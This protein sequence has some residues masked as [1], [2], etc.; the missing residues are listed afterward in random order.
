MFTTSIGRALRVGFVGVVPILLLG[1]IETAPCHGSEIDLQLQPDPAD[2]SYVEARWYPGDVSGVSNYRLVR[3]DLISGVAEEWL[4]PSDVTF[5]ILSFPD[6]D[7]SYEILVEA[8]DVEGSPVASSPQEAFIAGEAFGVTAQATAELLTTDSGF[9]AILESCNSQNFPFLFVSL[10]VEEDG[11][12]RTDL[13]ES[14]FSCY[15]DGRLQEDFFAVVPPEVGGGI[16]QADVVFLIDTSGSM[17]PEIA[18]VKAN[19]QTFAQDLANSDVDFRLG[20]VKFGNSSGP[21]PFVFNSGALTDDIALFQSFV[22]SLIA[23]GGFEPGFL[24]IRLA[25]S[26]FQFRPGSSL[27]FI[28]ISDEDSDDRDKIST[29]ELLLANEVTAHV[30]VDCGF[31]SSNS[32]YCLPCD[33][34]TDPLGN[35]SVRG[36]TDGLLFGVRDPFG[37]ILDTI[38]ARTAGTYIARYRSDNPEFDGTERLVECFVSDNGLSDSV[39]CSYVPGAA[40]RIERTAETIALSETAQVAGSQVRIEAFVTD[41]V[42]PF[43]TEV[44]VFYRTTGTS[45]AYQSRGMVPVDSTLYSVELPTAV[46]VTPGVD[47]YISAA[48]GQVTSFDPSTEP[49]RHPYQI[50]VLPNEPPDIAHSPL[51]NGVEGIA[52]TVSAEIDDTTNHL[53]SQQLHWRRTGTLIYSAADMAAGVGNVFEAQI[54]PVDVTRD[55][56]DYYISATDDLGLTATVGT[57]DVPFQIAVSADSPPVITA[58]PQ[59][60]N[61]SRF[62]RLGELLSSDLVAS[63]PDGNELV[64]LRVENL[65]PT[66]RTLPTLPAEGNPISASL[67]WR[68]KCGEFGSYEVR[69][70]ASEPD[71]QFTVCPVNIGF[72]ADNDSDNDCLTDE[73]ECFWKTD[74]RDPDTDGDALF[75]GWEVATPRDLENECEPLDSDLLPGAHPLRKDIFLEIDWMEN[76]DH[77]HRP[78]GEAISLVEEAFGNAPVRVCETGTRQN[79]PCRDDSECPLSE[80]GRGCTVQSGIN[81]HIDRDDSIEHHGLICFE[82]SRANCPIL[83]TWRWFDTLKEANF[84]P[85]RKRFWH[86][87]IFGHEV[88]S[89]L[90]SRTPLGKAEI[91]GN[92]LVVGLGPFSNLCE[93]G[94][95]NHWCDEDSDCLGGT[96]VPAGNDVGV[97]TAF[98]QAGV[99]MHE[100]GHN[101]GLRHGGWEN[102]NYKPN[103]LSVMNYYFPTRGI[104]QRGRTD[105]RLDYSGERLNLVLDE[106]ELREGDG[107]GDGDLRVYYFCPRVCK[108]GPKRGQTCTALSECLPGIC[109][110]DEENPRPVW[111]D[112]EIDWNCNGQL[113]SEH[114]RADVNKDHREGELEGQDDWVEIRFD[115]QKSPDF[116]DFVHQNLPEDEID[117]ETVNRLAL[118][119]QAVDVEIDIKPGSYPNAVNLDSQGVVPVAILSSSVFDAASIIPKSVF[120]AGSN[121]IRHGGHIEDVNGD[122]RADL[123][124]HYETP[125]LLYLQ[126]D[127]D[128]GTIIGRTWDRLLVLGEDS[129]RVVSE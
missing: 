3:V 66:A 36:A 115:F 75:D 87:A 9:D 46:V 41:E 117:I 30:A 55:G 57:A 89:T 85:A 109:T 21:N 64:S 94:E 105:G 118:D 16:R 102:T 32:D 76:E 121:D 49:A 67:S 15:E 103:Y 39:S 13:P 2:S 100:F 84:E 58:H 54:P 56:V 92:D 29:L 80:W 104:V 106:G 23:S 35:C 97:G 120:F 78:K 47:Y 12:P 77:S 27:V 17:G 31:G 73:E 112:R 98:L 101:L 88:S 91:W 110:G 51:A 25:I 107:I 114:V 86:Y 90:F 18:E 63:D 99:L 127:S 10:R 19:V 93:G 40:P 1:I 4:L 70:I 71:G 61:T 53:V 24:A 43:V 5:H 26:T 68:P 82:E 22:N 11:T 123:L 113:D 72:P 116:A 28:L 50:A 60:C 74:P 96:C 59:I 125:S 81:L 48:D 108:G 14:S 8:L 122:G 45:E 79:W 69:F 65:P 6:G 44:R 95:T 52:I 37:P 62:V 119:H 111:G 128:S 33:A 20:L 124:L 83:R 42:E 34:S 126:Q 7:H 129:V 38:V